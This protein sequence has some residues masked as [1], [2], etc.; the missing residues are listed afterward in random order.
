MN[1]KRGVAL[2]EIIIRK[3]F[4]WLIAFIGMCH[5]AACAKDIMPRPAKIED[6]Q[7][8][9][10]ALQDAGANLAETT[11][12]EIVALEIP[13]QVLQ[14]NSALVYVYEY[15]NVATR[16]AI[17]E[18]LAVDG[19]RIGRQPLHWPDRINIWVA[20]RLIVAYAGTDGATIVLLNGLLGDPITQPSSPVDEP[21]P[22]AVTAAV[23]FL[24]ERLDVNPANVE[25]TWFAPETWPDACLGLPADGEMCAQVETP[26]YRI[27][28]FVGT[29]EFEVH[30]DQV[31]EHIRFK[32]N[33]D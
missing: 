23:G 32:N 30:S 15:E 20:E 4:K 26:G 11:V 13:P 9:I 28:M 14:V 29:E 22:P 16:A 7:D 17:S 27:L 18:S 5:L 8:L 19:S 1:M 12:E 2:F 10:E 21:F 25:V 33:S 3:Q 31:G 24:A 6:T